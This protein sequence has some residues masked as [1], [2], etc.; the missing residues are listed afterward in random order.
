[1]SH[2]GFWKAGQ[3]EGHVRLL[4]IHITVMVVVPP[5]CPPLLYRNGFLYKI[6]SS[7]NSMNKI[8]KRI[9]DRPVS[10]TVTC[11]RLRR[12]SPFSFPELDFEKNILTTLNKAFWPPQNEMKKL[13]CE[14]LYFP[15]NDNPRVRDLTERIALKRR[16]HGYGCQFRKWE[17]EIK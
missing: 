10:P 4:S 11:T 7:N 12:N 16:A 14:G 17:E 13:Y 9:A 1:M 3:V 8:S 2:V 6:H 5:L 15:H